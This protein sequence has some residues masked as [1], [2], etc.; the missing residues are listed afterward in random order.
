MNNVVANELSLRPAT[1]EDAQQLAHLWASTFPDK[2][3]PVLGKKAEAVLSDWLRLSQRHLQTT[4]LAQI[5]ETVAGYIVLETPTAPRRN[6]GRWLWHALQLHYGLWGALRGL[7]LMLLIDSDYQG[8]EDE[9]HIE[10]L[11]VA[12]AWRGRGVACHLIEHAET[13][14]EAQNIKLLS[15]EVVSDNKPAIQLYEKTGFV[16]KSKQRSYTLKWITGHSEYY[17]MVKQVG[18]G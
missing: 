16:I 17:Q 4:T 12:P 1:I 5:K 18:T 6:D 2:F 3:G 9:I 11:G 13:T 7:L 10:M 15:L 14:A 8:G